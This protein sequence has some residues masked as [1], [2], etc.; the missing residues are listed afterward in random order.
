MNPQDDKTMD[1][2]IK[3]RMFLLMKQR[4]ETARE[5]FPHRWEN[6]SH[7]VRA[8]VANFLQYLEQEE[9]LKNFGGVK[10]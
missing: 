10:K 2:V 7:F 6:N 3:V 8:A 5:Q 1:E 9:G 4:I